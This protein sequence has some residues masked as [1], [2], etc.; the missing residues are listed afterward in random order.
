VVVQKFAALLYWRAVYGA[1]RSG[2]GFVVGDTGVRI[3]RVIYALGLL[4]FGYAHFAN[5]KGTAALVPG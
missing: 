5:A 2:I 1:D 3:A 4:P